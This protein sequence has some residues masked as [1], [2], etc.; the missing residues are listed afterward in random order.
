MEYYNPKDNSP[1][2]WGAAATLLYVVLLGCAM[3]F[4]KCEVTS[5]DDII[6]GITIQFGDSDTG[7]GDEEL[8]A[9]DVQ[10]SKTTTSQ[11]D[12]PEQIATDDRNDVTIDRPT[13]EQSPK[14]E[15]EPD[16]HEQP[17]PEEKPIPE[18]RTVNQQALFPGRKTDSE[19][20]SQG[21][22]EGTNNQGS[23]NGKPEGEAIG[24]SEGLSGVAF[25]LEGRSIVGSLP[26][27]S[28]YN[29]NLSGVVVIDV[30]VDESGRVKSAN[31]QPIGSTTNNSQL[32]EAAR[33]AA[34]KARFSTSESFIQGGTITYTF[35][36]N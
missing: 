19:S 32:T 18:E 4:T 36:L 27:P 29:G 12:V 25:S 26:K 35:K 14:Q 9:T 16:T 20:T 33:A 10:A 3:L 22:T 13:E 2:H 1:K 34:L 15:V 21:T 31:Y 6:D 8:L 5:E 30:T 28:G 23:T 11:P 24:G 7:Q 17:I